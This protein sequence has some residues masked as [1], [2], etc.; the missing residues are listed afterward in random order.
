MFLLIHAIRDSWCKY[1]MCICIFILLLK[2]YSPTNIQCEQRTYRNWRNLRLRPSCEFF[3]LRWLDRSIVTIQ[4]S[5]SAGSR[6]K[7]VNILHISSEKFLVVIIFWYEKNWFSSIHNQ[8]AT[9]FL[10]TK[11]YKNAKSLDLDLLEKRLRKAKRDK[12]W[13]AKLFNQIGNFWRI[14]GNAGKAIDCFRSALSL[15]PMNTDVLHDLARVLFV[16][17]YLDDAIFLVK[18]SLE[19]QSNS[20]NAWRSFF[21]LGEIYRA[22]GQFQQSI[23][24]FR[25]ALELNPNHEP[26]L[27]AI[28]DMENS[29][30]S[31]IQFYTIVIICLLVRF[32]RIFSFILEKVFY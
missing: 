9:L 29:A 12:P 25:Q 6:G 24:Y 3:I 20:R 31:H 7:S 28:R 23:L 30:P 2:Q 5:I 16:L 10:K 13:N 11:D 18:R 15:D 4:S 22:Y 32:E 8:A 14:K 19:T 1:S 26:I 27:I 21:T 17:Q